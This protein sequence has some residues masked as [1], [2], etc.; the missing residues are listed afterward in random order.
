MKSKKIKKKTF[1]ENVYDDDSEISMSS[2]N[3]MMSNKDNEL[4]NE[5]HI[6]QNDDEIEEPTRPTES[7]EKN[8]RTRFGRISKAPER[9]N[10][11]QY[12]GVQEI[13]EEYS[14]ENPR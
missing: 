4:N 7:V 1:H 11:S 14:T 9:L 5:R 10:L 6:H 8:T 12:G 3:S 2:N 13:V